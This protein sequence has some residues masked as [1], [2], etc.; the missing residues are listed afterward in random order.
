MTTLTIRHAMSLLVIV[1]SLFIFNGCGGGGSGNDTQMIA[2][3]TGE[4]AVGLLATNKTVVIIDV[5]TPAEYVTGYVVGSTNIDFQAADFQTRIAAL[6]RNAEYLVYCASGGRSSQAVAVMDEL[7]FQ[8]VFN[9]IGGLPSIRSA[10]GGSA[11]I[12]SSLN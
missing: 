8:V 6:N 2:D 5:R 12:M 4:Q 7:G 9:V 10:P 3:I 1:P 11:L